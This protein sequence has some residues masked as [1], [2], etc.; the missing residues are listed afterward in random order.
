VTVALVLTSL[1]PA[2]FADAE[3]TATIYS[4]KDNTTERGSGAFVGKPGYLVTAYHV[5]YGA[6]HITILT[7]DGARHENPRILALLP[8]NDLALLRIDA[9]TRYFDIESAAPLTEDELIVV[10]NVLGIPNQTISAKSTSNDYVQSTQ[11]STPAGRRLFSSQF[12][13]RLLPLDVTVYDGMS[14]AP[15][16]DADSRVRGILSGSYAEGRGYAWAIPISYVRALIDSPPPGEPLSAISSDW[17]PL[18]ILAADSFTLGLLRHYTPTSSGDVA[19]LQALEFITEAWTK[20]EGRWLARRTEPVN[21]YVLGCKGTGE[22]VSD[23]NLT[24]FSEAEVRGTIRH[25]VDLKAEFEA[26]AVTLMPALCVDGVSPP[27]CSDDVRRSNQE[28]LAQ[29]RG[30]CYA[31]VTGEASNPELRIAEMFGSTRVHV[32]GERRLRL[33]LTSDHEDCLGAGCQLGNIG[34]QP[35]LPVD[36]SGGR[37]VLGIGGEIFRRSQ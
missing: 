25:T 31:S 29:Y 5:V 7:N 32:R 27:S 2:S 21:T 20:L 1:A 14:G 9:P 23:V 35:S 26:S 22:A 33:A 34:E 12:T 18:E 4:E 24:V 6:N 8:Q 17:P 11:F 28:R 16:I 36:V 30:E 15:V 19:E 10:A 37:N 13:T 3:R